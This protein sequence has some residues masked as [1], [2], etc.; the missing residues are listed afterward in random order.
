MQYVLSRLNIYLVCHLGS[1][2]V[3]SNLQNW[4]VMDFSSHAPHFCVCNRWISLR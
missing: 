2:I 1:W 4:V 3:Y